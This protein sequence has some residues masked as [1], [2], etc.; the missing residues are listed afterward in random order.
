MPRIKAGLVKSHSHFAACQWHT[1]KADV[2][3]IC[4]LCWLV[5]EYPPV[6][7]TTAGALT[8]SDGS[9]PGF[10]PAL[11]RAQWLQEFIALLDSEIRG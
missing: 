10:E 2:V 6:F 3:R 5:L 9:V 4:S 11:E 8:H 1:R 7:R